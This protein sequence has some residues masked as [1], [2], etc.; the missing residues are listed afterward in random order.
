M[1]NHISSGFTLSAANK[2]SNFDSRRLSTQLSGVHSKIL[3]GRRTFQPQWFQK[4]IIIMEIWLLWWQWWLCPLP[5][6]HRGLSSYCN[7]KVA[8]E[9]CRCHGTVTTCRSFAPAFFTPKF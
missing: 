3:W 6:M 2:T 1:H 8:I 9:N 5:H 4:C 7:W